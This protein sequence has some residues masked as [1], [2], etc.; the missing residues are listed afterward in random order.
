M[1]QKHIVAGCAC[2]S[3][4]NYPGQFLCPWRYGRTPAVSWFYIGPSAIID[5][6]VHEVLSPISAIRGEMLAVLKNPEMQPSSLL[7]AKKLKMRV[8]G[9]SYHI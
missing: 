8:P 2:Q 6:V 9:T 5:A 4:V 1:P 3:N 7:P